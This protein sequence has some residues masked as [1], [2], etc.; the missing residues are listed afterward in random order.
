[1]K[2]N[3]LSRTCNFLGVLDFAWIKIKIAFF[4]F[5]VIS[6]P[7]MSLTNFIL[8]CYYY[9]YELLFVSLNVRSIKLQLFKLERKQ[10]GFRHLSRTTL[11]RIFL[12]TP[13]VFRRLGNP[14]WNLAF[15]IT[16]IKVAVVRDR[17]LCNYTDNLCY[18]TFK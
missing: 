1:M 11:P 13:F 12:T 17:W 4:F 8:C 5:L 7:Q 10:C 6:A 14:Q 15:S 18:A 2:N 3:F 9:T 16:R